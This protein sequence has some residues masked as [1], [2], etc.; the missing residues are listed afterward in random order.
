M[1]QSIKLILKFAFAIG[2]IYWLIDSGKLDLKL[3]TVA[4]SEPLRL[5]IG[6]SII[7]LNLLLVTWRYFIIITAKMETSPPFKEIFKLNWI[8]IFFNSILPGSV[9]GDIVK[10]FYLKEIDKTLSNRFLLASVLIDRFVGLF[11]LILIMGFFSIINYNELAG[12]SKNLKMVTHLNIIL[13]LGVLFS[14]FSLFFFNTLPHKILNVFKSV[15]L[16]KGVIPKLLD[17]WDNL[18]MLRSK[19]LTV[20]AL[21]MV[22]QTLAVISFWYITHPYAEGNFPFSYAFSFV[23]LGFVFIA[24]PIAPSGMGVGHAAFATLFT[25]IGINNGASLFNIYFILMLSANLL[26]VIPY[27]L[28]GKT[29]KLDP[30]ELPGENPR[31]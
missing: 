11:G 12:I 16:L 13:F 10:V 5:V 17:A 7:L 23:P 15:P 26:G 6:F 2:I 4:F 20:T 18:C 28:R 24:L 9:S 21:S 8:G 3:L 14:L 30:A 19:M 29:V 22:I 27:I 25:Y 31:D 1:S